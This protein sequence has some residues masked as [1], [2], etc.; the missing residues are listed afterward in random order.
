ML[1]AVLLAY[2]FG[3]ATVGVLF[4]SSLHYG[5]LTTTTPMIGGGAALVALAIWHHYDMTHARPV[6]AIAVP[7]PRKQPRSMSKNTYEAWANATQPFPAPIFYSF[8]RLVLKP[9]P[10]V[11]SVTSVD[12]YSAP[13]APALN[14]SPWWARQEERVPSAAAASILPHTSLADFFQ[15]VRA[16]GL[17]GVSA[18]EIEYVESFSVPNSKP[19]VI[20]VTSVDLYTAPQTPALNYSPSWGRQEERV[21][22][23]I[24]ASILPHSSP[25]DAFRHVRASGLAGLSAAGI[26]YVET[27][28]ALLPTSPLIGRAVPSKCPAAAN[29]T[30]EVSA[31]VPAPLDPFDWFLVARPVILAFPPVPAFHTMPAFPSLALDR[32][33][34][35]AFA[36][37]T[38][39][40]ATVKVLVPFFGPIGPRHT[41]Q[42]VSPAKT[43]H[44]FTRFREEYWPIIPPFPAFS[45]I[46][47]FSAFPM[48]GSHPTPLAFAPATKCNVTVETAIPF[49]GPLNIQP[50]P[51]RVPLAKSEDPFAPY[52]ERRF[53]LRIR[54]I[55]LVPIVFS[56]WEEPK[57]RNITVPLA[58]PV[59]EV[60]ALVPEE[61][62]VEADKEVLLVPQPLPFPRV[63]PPSMGHTTIIGGR[64][65][66]LP[67]TPPRTPPPSARRLAELQ[68]GPLTI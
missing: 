33:I 62:R 51:K 15:L 55:L 53:L 11:V 9:T 29:E 10:E 49:I 54:C 22:S 20:S 52:G 6:V 59:P 36:P 48:F 39:G 28:S 23:A 43:Q 32:P 40:N 35:A 46:S 60:G 58:V 1:P 24:V 50:I 3:L 47:P 65:S 34:P 31:P 44:L 12:L 68:V 4:S 57:P 17:A 61:V 63:F 14:Y 30:L 41:P 42:P 45:A 38:N 13:Q 27:F 2:G 56:F 67:R 25:A 7:H 18:T 19:E 21:P 8:D 26:E 64:R 5:R 37:V 66:N 16:S